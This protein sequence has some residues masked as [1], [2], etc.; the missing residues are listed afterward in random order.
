MKKAEVI[1]E[2]DS[3]FLE[4]IQTFAKKEGKTLEAAAAYLLEKGIDS[5]DK[6]EINKQ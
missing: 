6:R 1:L 5:E 3:G 2:L 4:R